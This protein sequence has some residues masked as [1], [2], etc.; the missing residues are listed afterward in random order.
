MRIRLLES[1]SGSGGG[2][3]SSSP[4]RRPALRFSARRPAPAVF[5]S[6]DLFLDLGNEFVEFPLARDGRVPPVFQHVSIQFNPPLE[7]AATMGTDSV[8]ERGELRGDAI[9]KLFD[10]VF[11]Y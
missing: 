2:L 7:D 11:A 1:Y 10:L 5:L 3:S 8:N 6:I 4:G 9:A